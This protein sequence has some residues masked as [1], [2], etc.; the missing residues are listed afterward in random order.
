MKD[1]SMSHITKNRF[2]VVLEHELNH[3]M[4]NRI[5]PNRT[6]PRWFK[7][8]FAMFYSNE[9]SL[10]HKLDVLNEIRI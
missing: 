6:I 3:I 2:K 7:E 9:I 1:P 5:D 10:N 8:G 4:V